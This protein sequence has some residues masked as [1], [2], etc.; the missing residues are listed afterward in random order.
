MCME[1]QIRVSGSY[2]SQFSICWFDV[3]PKLLECY[4][5]TVQVFR[6]DRFTIISTMRAAPSPAGL[7]CVLAPC[8]PEFDPPRGRICW[9]E[10]TQFICTLKKNPLAR[11]TLKH[12]S[13]AGSVSHG[14]RCCCAWV[15]WGFGDFLDLR[16]RL[17]S[18]LIT[19]PSGRS[20][21]GGSSFF[22]IGT[23]L[24]FLIYRNSS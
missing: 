17:S 24:N 3:E 12:R 16:E 18:T 9:P 2:T 22:I 6:T 15:E 10:V 11:S 13:K 7:G 19:M 23:M 1:F 5:F 14:L 4:T 20:Y 21:P 8:R